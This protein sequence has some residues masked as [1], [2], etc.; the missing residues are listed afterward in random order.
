MYIYIKKQISLTKHSSITPT[1][2]LILQRNYGNIT[3]YCHKINVDILQGKP[4]IHLEYFK[5]SFSVSLSGNICIIYL[6]IFL[7]TSREALHNLQFIKYVY[8]ATN[9]L[10]LVQNSINITRLFKVQIIG[11]LRYYQNILNNLKKL[12]RIKLMFYL[13]NYFTQRMSM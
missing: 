6:I 3:Q 13:F 5:D 9:Y 2:V 12:I 10:V 1:L 7:D 8:L 4:N 11:K